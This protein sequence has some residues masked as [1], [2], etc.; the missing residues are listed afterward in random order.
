M[1]DDMVVLWN[2]TQHPKSAVDIIAGALIELFQEDRAT[3]GFFLLAC[4]SKGS[5]PP[6][7]RARELEILK[8]RQLVSDGSTPAQ[9]VISM[10]MRDIVTS[11]LSGDS[12]R[13]PYAESPR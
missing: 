13:W 8:S 10:M 7:M 6:R 11:M 9:V 12:L 5:R 3:F 2:G 1:S 4:T